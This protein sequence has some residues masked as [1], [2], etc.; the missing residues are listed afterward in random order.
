M[1]SVCAQTASHKWNKS[2][3]LRSLRLVLVLA[4]AARLGFA[5]APDPVQWSLAVDSQ[6]VPPGGKVLAR[7]TAT[8][9]SGWHVYS[10]TTP[11]G[12]P[13]PTTLQLAANPSVAEVHIYQPKP[14]RKLDPNFQL[15]TE[16]FQNKVVF[17]LEIAFKKDAA[18]G[19]L[20]LTAQ[21][22]YQCCNETT[23]LPPKRK[24][25]V[26]SL[27]LDPSA[28]QPAIVIPAGYSEVPATPTAGAPTPAK[29]APRPGNA[30]STDAQDLGGFLLTAFGL[31][32][33]SIFT[34]CVFPMIPITVS[35][36]LNRKSSENK[37]AA[38]RESIIHAGLFCVGIIVLFTGLGWLAKAIAGPFGVVLL[39]S[40]PWVNGFITAVFVVFGLSLLGAFELTLPSGLLTRLNSASGQ[41][42]YAGTLIMGLTFTLTSFAC[43]GPIVGPLFVA[44]V[45]T[46]GLQPVLGMFAFATGLAAPFF[47][48]AL[49]PSYLQRLPRSGGWMIRVKVVLGFL[50]LAAAVNYL[51]KMNEA[52][53]I[54]W[55]TRERYLAAWVVLFI[56][57]GLYL[58]GLLRMEGI[59]ADEKLGVGRAL[60]AA[61]F[62][63]FAVSLLP[64]MFGAPLGELDAY[65]PV[66]TSKAM[67][68]GGGSAAQLTWIQDD[69]K[70]AL[71]QARRENKL[72]FVD[73]SGHAC[74][75]CHWMERN[76]LPRPEIQAALKNF[77]LVQLFTD[78]TDQTSEENQ[79]LQESKFA[80]I[81]I[82]YYAILDSG[83]NIVATF[84]GLTRD[85]KAF[86]A[87]LDGAA[88]PPAVASR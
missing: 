76:M 66:S 37:A 25:A 11:P 32:L 49:F 38:R 33:A 62:L 19:P 80:T 29:N 61:V 50:V 36:F 84:P 85:P 65:I 24:T 39:G 31:G 35:F 14:E 9:E 60:T 88:R 22:R 13:N 64:G 87:F 30:P 23:C 83:E 27:R 3:T 77:V 7:L 82:P 68:A 46:N 12:G 74:T 20:D 73:F 63:I 17:L 58:L 21:V 47:V 4:A 45:Q 34:P 69:Y 5:A 53:Q 52:L 56:L 78:G 41:G 26:A 42:G 71:D 81:A 16:T 1:S 6:S 67:F 57:P 70:K 2:M 79:K 28:A 10:P 40:N 55:L 59:K 72:V 75:N 8:I 43:I 44:S 48:L 18:A 15:D 51:N 54:G 86:L